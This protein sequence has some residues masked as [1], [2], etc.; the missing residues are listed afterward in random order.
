MSEIEGRAAF[1]QA[2]VRHL[3]G[4][5]A[6]AQGEIT[7]LREALWKAIARLEQPI[8]HGGTTSEGAYEVYDPARLAIA[9]DLRAAL[10]EG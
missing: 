3:T 8:G 7:R 5:V 4:T 2:G 9:A 10:T 6:D 1:L